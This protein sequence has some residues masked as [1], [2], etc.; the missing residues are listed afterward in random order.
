MPRP[1]SASDSPLL[2]AT[3]HA[4][5]T[6][7]PGRVMALIAMTW[8]R[9]D[10][11]ASRHAAC[12]HAVSLERPKAADRPPST[13]SGS[14]ISSSGPSPPSRSRVA[15]PAEQQGCRWRRL[16]GAVA[17]AVSERDQPAGSRVARPLVH[18][19]ARR[20]RRPRPTAR[21]GQLGLRAPWSRRPGGW[22]PERVRRS[23]DG[24]RG[25]HRIALV[26]VDADRAGP[27]AR[28]RRRRPRRSRPPI[29]GRR[30][31][32]RPVLDRDGADWTR[33]SSTGHFAERPSG[34]KRLPP[35]LERRNAPARGLGE[36]ARCLAPSYRPLGPARRVDRPG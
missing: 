18:Q 12:R 7:K 4:E 16:D 26:A 6:S 28:L 22:R 27:S 20:P 1:R 31:A 19:L 13:S 29:A 35:S 36:D 11:A 33:S 30:L 3:S 25:A 21:S 15:A 9:P 10:R 5:L 17:A 32:R 34:R 24:I 23:L 14:R 2:V 8:S